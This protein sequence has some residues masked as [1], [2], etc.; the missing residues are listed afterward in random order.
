M[1]RIGTSGYS[2]RDWVGVFYPDGTPPGKMLE[3]YAKNFN[4]AE[5]NSTYYRIPPPGVFA[6]MARR[7]PDGFHFVVKTH[8]SMTHSRDFDADA[9]AVFNA[10]V[11]PL[12]DAGKLLGFLAQFPWSF[13]FAPP[14]LD[15]IRRLRDSFRAQ[16]LHVEFRHDSWLR[17][18]V[19]ETLCAAD[20]GFCMV[21]EPRL[22]GL[23]PPVARAT[24]AT[25]YVRFHGR[26]S[27]DW[28]R[29]RKGSDRYNYDYSDG[30]LLE[31]VPAIKRLD[32]ECDTVLLF[33]NNCHFGRA[34]RNAE[35]MARI[36]GIELRPP[37]RQG[38]LPME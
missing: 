2:F 1:V 32:G 23:I 22:E 27:T 28:W 18:D 5:V 13:R 19:F 7:T 8:K 16:S 12:R 20:I 34:P 33:F 9:L 6:G 15:Y 29:P 21:D 36:L 26:N 30:E 35:R 14:N 24:T 11:Q 37:P 10:A 4:V 17:D 31:W 38:E 25:A 3:F